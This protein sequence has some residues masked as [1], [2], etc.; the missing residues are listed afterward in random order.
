MQ[1]FELRFSLR[2]EQHQQR[3][4]QVTRSLLTCVPSGV[5]ASGALR[6]A[7]EC[8]R[9][10]QAESHRELSMVSRLR[11]FGSISSKLESTSNKAALARSVSSGTCLLTLIAFF[12]S[13][14]TCLLAR[15][16]LILCLRKKA[17]GDRLALPQNVGQ[18]IILAGFLEKLDFLQVSKKAI[19]RDQNIFQNYESA[20]DRLPRI[21]AAMR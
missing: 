20:C 21:Q 13:A 3:F 17:S 10:R 11:V 12:T 1:L 5:M 16:L 6:I 2:T 7:S 15:S 9:D 14:W 19:F 18:Q 8:V 4:P